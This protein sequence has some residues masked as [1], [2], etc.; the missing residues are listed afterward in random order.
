MSQSVRGYQL[1]YYT[2]WARRV[3]TELGSLTAQL[4]DTQS[5]LASHVTHRTQEVITPQ[6]CEPDQSWAGTECGRACLSLHRPPYTASTVCHLANIAR[7]ATVTRESSDLT[8]TIVSHDWWRRR[9]RVGTG[10]SDHLEIKTEER[11]ARYP[12]H[13]TR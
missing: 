7:P 3:I 9:G 4:G 1:I 8:A 12:E 5:S 2:V 6:S 13:E 11:R 10:S